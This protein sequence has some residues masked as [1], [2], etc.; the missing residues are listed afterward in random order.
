M[1]CGVVWMGEEGEKKK[2][3]VGGRGYKGRK[4]KRN[5]RK[6]WMDV[7][8]DGRNEPESERKVRQSLLHLTSLVLAWLNLNLNLRT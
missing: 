4:G 2:K 8:Q 7:S 6:V 1:D 5:V 3:S